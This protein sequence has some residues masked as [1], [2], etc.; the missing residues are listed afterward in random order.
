M[1]LDLIIALSGLL[2]GY[3]LGFMAAEELRSGIQHF[4]SAQ[5]TFFLLLFLVFITFFTGSRL[6]FIALAVLG[7]L[8]FILTYHYNTA[9]PAV[10][11][12]LFVC[13]PYFFIS[14]HL[15][16]SSLLFLYGLPAGTRLRVW[17]LKRI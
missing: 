11:S 7:V 2:V 4:I 17:Q 15:L 8:L 6:I 12:Y 3:I 13:I 9:L 16:Y 1:V 10:A 5:T 14:E